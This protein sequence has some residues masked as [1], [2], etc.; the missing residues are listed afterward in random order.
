MHVK[1]LEQNQE[2]SVQEIETGDILMI[3]Q[4]I[5]GFLQPQDDDGDINTDNW[6]SGQV[7]IFLCVSVCQS[8]C[9]SV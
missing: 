5:G 7:Y 9:W 1:E 4:A 3:H 8:V 2:E 6:E